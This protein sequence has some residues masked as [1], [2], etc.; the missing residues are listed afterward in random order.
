MTPIEQFSQMSPAL[1]T[2]AKALR[3]SFPAEQQAPQR[4]D[5][6]VALASEEAAHHQFD[7]TALIPFFKHFFNTFDANR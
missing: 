4:F 1:V 6:F 3:E 7:V 5:L 2:A